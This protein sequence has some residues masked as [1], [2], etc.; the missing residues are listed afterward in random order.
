M[1]TEAPTVLS[2]PSCRDWRA[3]DDDEY[4][5]SGIRAQAED[6]PSMAAYPRERILANFRVLARTNVFL[7]AVAAQSAG[8][9]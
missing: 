8:S 4:Y 3:A 2:V 5:A 9:D 6:S 1:E 7:R